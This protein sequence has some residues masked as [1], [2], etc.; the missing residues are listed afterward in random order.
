MIP[1][2]REL[3]QARWPALRPGR[4]APAGAI[5][6][7]VDRSPAAKVTLVFFDQAGELAAI[8]KVARSAV[9]E[10]ALEQEHEALTHLWSLGGGA[11]SVRRQVPQP[12]LLERVAGRLALVV[13]PLAGRPM[14]AA[15][16]TPGHV[17]DQATVAADFTLA[18]TW[19]RAFQTETAAP[20]QPF[21]PNQLDRWV[22]QV[23]RD[24]RAQ[25]G[26]SA[27]EEKLFTEVNTRAEALL[28][29]PLPTA[30]IHG[31]YWM[32]NLLVDPSGQLRGVIDWERGRREGPCLLDIYKFPTSYGLYLDRAYPSGV[33]PG[34]PDRQRWQTRWPHLGDWLHLAGF[35]YTY[36]GDGWFPQ[37]I[38]SFII[39]H[40]DALSV[41]HA[42][43]AVFFP[44]FLAEQALLPGHP[45]TRAANR[46]MLH[47]FGEDP[48]GTWLWTSG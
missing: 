41:P 21:D 36:Y 6:A 40:L 28:G 29:L 45:K 31:D 4:P 33:V 35:G 43:N 47:A 39:S 27:T 24:Y 16:Y 37:Q 22:G 20:L 1:P 25:V 12:L 13:S 42:A 3:L 10:P 23:I 38:R 17:A 5:V 30:A 26:W 19:L 11:P 44:L 9:S 2:L 18:A 8:A 48:T 34:H 46:A 14:T 32:G 15:Y 7:G